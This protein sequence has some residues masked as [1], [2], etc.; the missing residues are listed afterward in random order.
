VREMREEIRIL[1]TENAQLKAKYFRGAPAPD[2]LPENEPESTVLLRSA[3][4]PEQGGQ[5]ARKVSLYDISEAE[6]EQHTSI[7]GAKIFI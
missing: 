6:I 7:K 3:S 2:E 1:R 4:S 5:K